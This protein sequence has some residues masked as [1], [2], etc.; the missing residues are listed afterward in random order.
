MSAE[1]FSD[2][3]ASHF[4]ELQQCFE[5]NKT[6]EVNERQIEFLGKNY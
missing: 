2:E 3:D 4:D 6:T 1:G 5:S